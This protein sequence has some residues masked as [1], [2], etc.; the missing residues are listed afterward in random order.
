MGALGR[1]LK[2]RSIAIVGGGAWC[3]NVVAANRAIGFDG[4][5]WPVHPTRTEVDGL[6]VYASLSALPAPPDACFLGVNRHATVALVEELA[7]MGAGGAVCFAAEFGES[8]AETGDG[9]ALQARLV[10]AAGDMPIVGPNCYGLLNYLD[11]AALWPDQHG[12]ARVERGV[13]IL[14]QSSNIACN[15]TMQTR[16]LPLAFV[17]TLGNQAQTGLSRLGRA[18][19][20]DPRI[21]ALGLHIE[22]ID[23]L[24]AFEALANHARALGKPVVALRVGLSEGAQ[25]AALSH[26]ASLAG[27][28]AGAKALLERLGIA[29]V[30]TL[31]AL[32]ETLKLLHVTGPLRS[33]RIASLSCSGGEASLVADMAEG[34]GLVFPSLGDRQRADLRAALGPNTA[35]ANPLDYQTGVWGDVAATTRAFTAMMQGDLA[36]GV[37]V[38]DL[39][40]ADRCDPADW[41][42]V[43]EAVAAT[44]AAT[45]IPMALLA[46][47]PENMPEAEVTTLAARGIPALCGGAE[48]LAAI[49]C[50]A[51][52]GT[53]KGPLPPLLLPADRA[54][55]ETLD[56]AAAKALL[57]R[58]GLAVPEG[59]RVADGDGAA[60]AAETLGFPVALKGTGAAH[61]SEAGLVALNLRDAG[62]VRDAARAMPDGPFLV[63]R[64]VEGALCELLVGVVSDPA[65]GHVLTLGAGGTRAELI[66]DTVS[67][68]LPVDGAAIRAALLRLRAAPLLTGFR[69]APAADM[70][71]VVTAVLA[72][73]AFVAANRAAV[74]EVEI[75]PLICTGTAAIAA[76]AL[77]RA[78]RG[79]LT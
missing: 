12:G 39:P 33:N 1:L 37:V 35:L 21:T 66:A 41:R 28:S 68:L 51:R 58:H 43:Y 6:P 30:F 77:I 34:S 73:Q 45:R 5:L 40:R 3:A 16:G 59:R 11:G 52:L 54:E 7:A 79:A 2:P 32:L 76:D 17:G 55:A 15:L 65:H 38:L 71:A 48:G 78:A 4:A 36:L 49:A 29:Q 60:E 44:R 72:V 74:Q 63:E 23:D 62:A 69:G 42:K 67:L 75:N 53:D 70:E 14:A 25:A 8:Q 24:A 9:T 31:P 50:A 61:K 18:L 64:M 13:A 56:E 26:T 22:G 27:S 47:Q 20:E 46:L 19:L 10:A 57:A